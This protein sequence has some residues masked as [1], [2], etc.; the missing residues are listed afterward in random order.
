MLTH[1]ATATDDNQENSL[2]KQWAAGAGN[3]P[4]GYLPVG[5]YAVDS[6]DPRLPISTV[7][8]KNGPI[9]LSLLATLLDTFDVMNIPGRHSQGLGIL[10]TDRLFLDS[11]SSADKGLALYSG[12]TR[13]IALRRTTTVD[14]L[15]PKLWKKVL[16]GSSQS[17][18]GTNENFLREKVY[19]IFHERGHDIHRE[20][21]AKLLLKH[22]LDKIDAAWRVDVNRLYD[23]IILKPNLR[24]PVHVLN[25]ERERLLAGPLKTFSTRSGGSALSYL[26]SFREVAADLYRLYSLEHLLRASG[27]HPMPNYARLVRGGLRQSRARVMRWFEGTYLTLKELVFSE[28]R[29]AELA[30]RKRELE[31]TETGLSE[32][33]PRKD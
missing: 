7:E 12:S 20:L 2:A 16:A 30:G 14:P 6:P 8:V 26:A 15:V 17:E 31:S 10:L 22:E 25:S 27:E 29:F 3:L 5:I 24:R 23:H 18:I 19:W 4:A 9:P 21:W 11:S 28:E 13:T 33:K 32:L 1:P